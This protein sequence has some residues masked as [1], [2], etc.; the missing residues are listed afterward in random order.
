MTTRIADTDIARIR[1]DANIVTVISEYTHLQA[2]TG[3]D[4]LGTCPR[5]GELALEVATSRKVWFCHTC[6]KGGDVITFVQMAS[7]RGFMKAAQRVCELAGLPDPV[8]EAVPDRLGHER[9]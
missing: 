7:D 8:L 2:A 5:C 9:L 4:L 6:N 1:D 3:E